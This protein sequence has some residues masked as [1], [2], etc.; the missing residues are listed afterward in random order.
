VGIAF[1]PLGVAA[2]LSWTEAAVFAI[3]LLVANVSE[4]LLPTITP[5]LA[6]GVAELARR[7]GLVKRLA[8][9]ETLGSTD[10]ICTD[11]T[12]KLTQNR[13]HL[14]SVWDASAHHP[15]SPELRQDLATVRSPAARP[16]SRPGG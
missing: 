6:V 7:G 16:S 10:V 12:G 8:A 5:A 11:K 9:I 15:P 2:G 1:L 4:G 13:M 3:G 14:H